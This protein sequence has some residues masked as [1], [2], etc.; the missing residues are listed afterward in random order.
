MFAKRFSYIMDA[1]SATPSAVAKAIGCD[2]SYIVKLRSGERAPKRGGRGARRI[3]EGIASYASTNDLEIELCRAV[4]EEYPPEDLQRRIEEYL[5]DGEE[6]EQGPAPEVDS[7]GSRLDAVMTLSG[8]S[9]IRLGRALNIDPSY[10]SRFRSGKRSPRS[11]PKVMDELCAVLLVKTFENG[12]EEELFRIIGAKNR[13]DARSSLYRWLYDVTPESGAPLVE[14]L[15]VSVNDFPGALKNP[16][17]PLDAVRA[18]GADGRNVYVGAE[19]LR[20]AVIRFLSL[21][22]DKRAPSMLL[23]S[24]QNME[25]MVADPSFRAR[26]ASLMAHAV[27]GGTKITI[28]HNV[29]RGMEEMASAIKSWLPLYP[30]GAIKSYYC[31]TPPSGRFSSTLF[32]APHGACISGFCSPGREAEDG[33]YRYD[34]DDALLSSLG[35]SFNSLLEK[36]EPL[37]ESAPALT[38]EEFARIF[39][40]TEFDVLRGERFPDV[41]VCYSE[42][43]VSLTR[44][45]QPKMSLIFRHPDL[46]RAFCAYAESNTKKDS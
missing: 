40:R 23:Y 4:G 45:A 43:A 46:C 5:F 17:L 10:V 11:N 37:A 22:I 15:I 20:A 25:W 27:R 13:D 29:D 32:L 30:S 35:A 9:N 34:E 14:E 26:W 12:R 39:R 7:F 21:V 3:C 36:C 6:T 42:S 18:S 33:V 41:E 44:L 19:G 8:I 31:K 2:R 24:D 1:L 38:A 28:I 16:I